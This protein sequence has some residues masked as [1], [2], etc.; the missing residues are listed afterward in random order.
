MYS[1]FRRLRHM[2]GVLPKIYPGVSHRL[3]AVGINVSADACSNASLFNGSSSIYRRLELAGCQGQRYSTVSETKHKMLITDDILSFIRSSLHQPRGSF[4]CWLNTT[5]GSKNLFKEDGI[6]LILIGEYLEG[7]PEAGQNTS[8]MFEKAKS[9]LQRYPSLQVVGLQYGKSMRLNSTSTHLLQRIIK[10]FVTFPILLCNK[11][12]FEMENVS[13]Y[14]ISKGFQTPTVYPGEDV[15]LKVLDQAIHDLNAENGKG[16]NLDDMKSSWVKP[17]EVVKEPDVC[18]ASR[19][20][21]FSFP[22]CISV[23]ESGNHLFLSDVNHHRIIVFD[24]NGKILDAIGSSPG[25]EDGE[26]EIAK[27]MR[28]AASFYHA[29]EDCLYFIDSENHAIRRA[30]MERRIVET[31]FP[32][33]D[34][35]RNN[36]GL[37]K[38]ILDKILTKRNIKAKSEEFNSDSFL[39]PWHI[40]RSSNNDVFVLNQSLG[41]LWIIDLESG[42][43]REVVKES[44]KILEICGQ[45]ILEKCVP[46]RQ[47]PALWLQQQVDTTGLFEGIPYAGLM[48][49][50]ATSQDH[51]VFCDIVGQTVVKL[52]KESGSATSFQFSNFGILGL[53]YWLASSL[54]RVYAVDDLSGDLDHSQCFR[55]LPGKVDIDLN[56]DVPHHTVLVEQPQEGCIW[57]QAR[58]AAAEVSGVENKA[59]SSEKVGAAQQWYDE[60]DNL[61]FSTPPEE[62]STEEKR[63]HPGQE[64]QEGRVR[65]GCTINTSPGTSEVIIYA[66]LY[67]RL[68]KSSNPHLDTQQSKAAKI[69]QILNPKGKSKKDLLIKLMTM[70][71]RDLE[72]LVFMRPLH[73]RL[74]FNCRDHPKA[75]NTKGVILTD[76][77]VKVHVTL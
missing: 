50:V 62:S 41:T 45:M 65:I 19:N 10:E 56:V 57:R 49:S 44:S 24:S 53:P 11:N 55:L 12:I 1:R 43:I 40:L 2:F 52:S 38:W 21:L 64:V 20:L 15:D 69:A 76:S 17:I 66:A 74:K 18:S 4:H 34:G 25:F 68:K 16:A 63:R 37:W 22:G 5:A 46:L 35:S 13:C 9:L 71:E 61:S 60:I 70:S 33:T 26:F 72:E 73:V 51:V 28:P 27:L 31:V 67:L 58:G 8:K 77:S 59:A 30:D 32:V 14:V 42:S 47:L 6:F 3:S 36:K 29:S 75:D 7:S 54:E 39:F 23:D 48:S